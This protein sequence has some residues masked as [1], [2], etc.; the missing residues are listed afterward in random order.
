MK[1]IFILYILLIPFILWANP[2]ENLTL[3]QAIVLAK[4]NNLELSIANINEKIK[5]LEV[6]MATSKHF[7]SLDLVQNVFRSNDAGNVFGYK[8]SNRK[9]SFQDFGFGEFLTN[10]Q[11]PNLLKTQPKDLNFP[12]D[13]TFYQTK[14]QYKL[15]IFT[16]GKIINYKAIQKSLLSIATLDKEKIKQEKIR[17][18]KKTYGDIELLDNFIKNLKTIEKNMDKLHLMTQNMLKE[19]YA[20]KVDMLEIKSKSSNVT[21]M[22]NQS[23]E[24]KILALQFLSFL[25]N[26]EVK[27]IDTSS[28]KRPARLNINKKDIENIIDFK[29]ANEGIKIANAM[30]KM[31]RAEF[32]PT[33]GLLAEYG[34]SSDKFLKDFKE[35]DFYTVGVQ[36]KWNIFN[37][38]ASYKGYEVARLGKLKATEQL[39]L[40]KEGLWLRILKLNNQ[41]NKLDFDIQSIKSELA[42]AKDIYKNY[43]G[44]YKESLVSV[45]DVL[46][47]HSS[48]LEL[49]LK[50]KELQNKKYDTIFA[51]NAT[52]QGE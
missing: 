51:L 29:K 48:L 20:K 19:G 28:Y 50:L 41:I 10:M 33:A 24:N 16:G 37:G 44:R 8:L 30:L 11:N 40:A 22:L 14:L 43:L 13:R 26:E 42:L 38:G 5:S 23:K 31:K 39:K 36:V 17:Q 1:Q 27:S 4:K 52:I 3:N 15:P 46:I 32:L 12:K 21:R 34:S 18:I 2:K 7:G 47:K 49:T 9:A 25:L 45:N 35:N 6:N